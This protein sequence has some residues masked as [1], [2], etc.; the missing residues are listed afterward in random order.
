MKH[1]IEFFGNQE[2]MS[3]ALGVTAAA[4]AQWVKAGKVPPMRAIQIE[5]LSKGK[6]K[7]V[8]MMGIKNDARKN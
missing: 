8:D 3:E 6:L 1:I 5:A 2:R 7:A 4:V